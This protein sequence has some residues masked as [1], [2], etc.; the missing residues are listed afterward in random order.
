MLRNSWNQKGL[1]AISLVRST[2]N[3]IAYHFKFLFPVFLIKFSW[4]CTSWHK[5]SLSN[6]QK[7][8]KL[9]FFTEFAPW[10]WGL[11]CQPIRTPRHITTSTNS[12]GKE[13]S[14]QILSNLGRITMNLQRSLRTVYMY[15][16]LVQDISLFLA[17]S[18]ETSHFNKEHLH[19]Y[20]V[21]WYQKCHKDS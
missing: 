20:V 9:S 11:L 16:P 10:K 14:C 6:K 13:K 8:L 18:L 7:A 21:N 19:L 4:I 17:F 3:Y 5:C 15:F 2:T 12:T 1:L